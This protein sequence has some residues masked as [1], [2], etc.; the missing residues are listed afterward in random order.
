MIDRE[1]ALHRPELVVLE[2]GA[3][4]LRATVGAGHAGRAWTAPAERHVDVV[5]VQVWKNQARQTLDI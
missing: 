1:V 5:G 4:A 2:A 3:H